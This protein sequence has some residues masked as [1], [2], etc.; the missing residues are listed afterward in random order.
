ME[1]NKGPVINPIRIALL[2]ALTYIMLCTVYIAFSTQIAAAASDSLS[3]LAMIEKI[4]GIAFV[5]ASGVLFYFISLKLLKR[6]AA[7][8]EQLHEQRKALVVSDR[9]AMAGSMAVSVAHDMNNQITVMHVGLEEL[10]THPAIQSHEAFR[11]LQCAVE[12]LS[13]L[14]RQLLN[15]GRQ[16]MTM[17]FQCAN[18][19]DIVEEVLE[20]IGRHP[21]TRDCRIT[22]SVANDLSMNLNVAVVSQMLFNLVLNA[23]DATNGHGVIQVRGY[24]SGPNVIIEVHDNGPGIPVDQRIE[25]AKPFFTTKE[26]GHG[27]GFVSVNACTEIHSGTMEILDSDLGGC[28]IKVTLPVKSSKVS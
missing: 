10:S 12:D 18:V 2:L 1:R 15:M 16:N 25:V 8:S 11:F 20:L 14:S 13:R 17:D 27:L 22:M 5:L 21:R 24:L 19:R 23:A 6:I 4:K 26:S 3:R 9:R 28:C 7:Q